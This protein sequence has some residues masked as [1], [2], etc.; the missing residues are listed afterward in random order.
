MMIK[1]KNMSV[2]EVLEM[3]NVGLIDGMINSVNSKKSRNRKD[4]EVVKECENVLKMLNEWK[5]KNGCVK[6]AKRGK[7]EDVD[8]SQMSDEDLAGMYESLYSRRCYYRKVNVKKF[9]EIEQKIDEVKAEKKR[10][11]IK[12]L[13]EEIK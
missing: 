9:E 13:S 3:G 12:K 8:I 4:K 10:R 5:V 11:M 6:S 7:Y 2:E 1:Y